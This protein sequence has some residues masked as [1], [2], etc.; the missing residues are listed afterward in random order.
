MHF[1]GWISVPCFLNDYILDY[2]K[3]NG[4]CETVFGQLPR[5]M[6]LAKVFSTAC[7]YE[8]SGP[9]QSVLC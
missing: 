2:L 7:L 6:H 4:V 5:M 1:T 8:N 3:A 9:N